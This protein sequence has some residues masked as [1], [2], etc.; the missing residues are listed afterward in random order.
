MQRH[1]GTLISLLATGFWILGPSSVHAQSVGGCG[2]FGGGGGDSFSSKITHIHTI[3]VDSGKY[4]DRIELAQP[5]GVTEA[6]GG[7]GG[8]THT[9]VVPEGA[10]IAGIAGS[11]GKYVDSIQF[12]FSN[13]DRSETFGGSGGN[14]YKCAV[15]KG[16]RFSGLHGSAGAYIDSIGIRWR[17]Y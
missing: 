8:T 4:V 1:I 12:L 5:N 2:P 16:C 13:G 10:T 15:P 11:A 6:F 9:I 17:C 3:V 7:S 14:D